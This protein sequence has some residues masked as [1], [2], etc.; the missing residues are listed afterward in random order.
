MSKNKQVVFKCRKCGH[1]LFVGDISL[2][3]FEKIANMDCPDCGE[4]GYENWILSRLGNYEEEY[5]KKD[6]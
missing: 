3:R 4:E 5:G 1:F 6:E 2:T